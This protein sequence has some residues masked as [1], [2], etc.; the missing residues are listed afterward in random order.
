L[1]PEGSGKAGNHSIGYRSPD[2][3][4][5]PQAGSRIV[6]LLIDEKGARVSLLAPPNHRL[7]LPLFAGAGDDYNEEEHYSNQ[8]QLTRVEVYWWLLEQEV[9]RDERI[10]ICEHRHQE[11]DS[12]VRILSSSCC[13]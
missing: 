10:R 5:I 8:D 6:R 9:A 7:L 13:T 1:D 2:R 4:I 11:H 3:R 12:H